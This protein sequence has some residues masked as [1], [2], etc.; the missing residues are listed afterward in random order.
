MIKLTINDRVVELEKPMTVLEAARA[1]GIHIPHFC[2]HPLL[3]KFAGCR[4]CLV[5]IE[6]ARGLQTSCTVRAS[7]GMVVR[8]E[9]QE[10]IKARKA[11]MEFFLINHPLDCPH[12]DKAGECKLQDYSVMYG[13]E[14]GRFEET[15]F[16][17]PESTRDPLIVR[18]MERCIMCTRCVR[19][20]QEVQGA[21]AIS[22]VGRG[23]HSFI[24]PFSGNR[25]DCDYC[26]LC[27]TVCPV[28]SLMSALHRHNYRPWETTSTVDTI[29][30]FC[31]VGCSVTIQMRGNSIQ[32]TIPKYRAG[33]NEGTLCARGFFGYEYPESTER[34][35]SPLIRKDGELVPV[36]FDEAISYTFQKLMGTVDEHGPSSVAAIASARCTNEDNYMLQRFFRG[37]L[38]SDNI[39]SIARLG[40]S[41]ARDVFDS[42]LGPG[43]TASPLYGIKNSGAILVLGCDP[44]TESPV[45]G[46]R[47]RNARRKGA[48]VIV[49]GSAPGLSAHTSVHVK[50]RPG[51][52]GHVLSALLSEVSRAA[53]PRTRNDA[54]E[55]IIGSLAVA[56]ESDM[57][58]CSDPESISRAASALTE[59]VG[60]VSIVFGRQIAAREHGERNL[61][62]AAALAHCLDAL[63]HICSESPNEN[64]L[65]DMGCAP[66]LL[67]GG[68][69][70]DNREVRDKYAE[71][72][73]TTLPDRPGIT[74]MEMMEGAASGDIKAMF[75]MGEN[76]VFNLPDSYAMTEALRKLDFLVV[77]DIFMTETA[78]LA[79]VV[80]PALGWPE[81]DGTFV[82]LERR[83]QLLKRSVTRKDAMEDWR[84]LGKLCQR[85]GMKGTHDSAE[86]VMKEVSKLSP[87]HKKVSHESI[88]AGADMFPYNGIPPEAPAALKEELIAE[89]AGL[90]EL[91]EEISLHPVLYR[92]LFHSGTLSR[93]S[94][95]LKTIMPEP[96]AVINPHTA[97]VSGLSEG[98]SVIAS[99]ARGQIAAKMHI[100]K[101]VPDNVVFISNNF[102]RSGLLALL[103][104]NIN[105]I[106]KTPYIEATPI[107]LKKG[108]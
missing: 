102:K 77:Q 92:P 66:G 7:D 3:E 23:K 82:N 68:V 94:K 5:E 29:C 39:D 67:P 16:T 87:L 46:V 25:F 81:K 44:T 85:A 1:N 18:N 45:L 26:G 108:G 62:L 59:C 101:S 20:C 43:S 99:T 72:Y 78:E 105:P 10:V 41:A 56:S 6:G 40:L 63:V 36:S 107:S 37:A 30:P 42:L 19:S 73:G 47:I 48:E 33:V 9:T 8:T 50:A 96:K 90:P 2:D 11:V 100:D 52:E 24:E 71:T 54:I 60:T 34:L 17:E 70:L 79:D 106:T 98:D 74:L 95:A 58:S 12:C 35:T 65:L 15:K 49:L 84:I 28:G 51:A 53:R 14:A 27:I 13:P 89:T 76:P 32:R 93:Y 4:M 83:I 97:S 69:P 31:G 38:G 103:G 61:A 86:D 64:G 80:F 57:I 21:S 22:V 75:V 91:H 104:Y 88:A 55:R